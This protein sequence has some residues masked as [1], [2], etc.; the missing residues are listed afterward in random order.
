M[1]DGPDIICRRELVVLSLFGLLD[2]APALWSLPTLDI[3]TDPHNLVDLIRLA[4]GTTTIKDPPPMSMEEV[5][6]ILVLPYLSQKQGRGAIGCQ[7][8][9][10][11]YHFIL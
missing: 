7:V 6:C 9:L 3:G 1:V 4:T 5:F 11:K 2:F 8:G 10:P